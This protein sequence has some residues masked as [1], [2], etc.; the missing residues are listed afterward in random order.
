MKQYNDKPILNKELF[1]KIEEELG[2]VTDFNIELKN[3]SLHLTY[4][5]NGTERTIINT[6]LSGKILIQSFIYCSNAFS[7]EPIFR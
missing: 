6:D 1:N 7:L 2:E 5:S 3:G 4:K